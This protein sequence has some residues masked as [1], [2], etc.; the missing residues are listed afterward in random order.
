[1]ATIER[2]GFAGY[3]LIVGFHP[4][5][6]REYRSARCGSGRQSGRFLMRITDIVHQYDL[7]LSEVS[8]P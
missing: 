7:L 6:A 3:F 1:M 2:M 8:Q 5:R 4:V